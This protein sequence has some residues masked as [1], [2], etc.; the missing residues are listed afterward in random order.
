[1]ESRDREEG[2]A[3]SASIQESIRSVL[4][5]EVEQ[6]IVD[7]ETDMVMAAPANRVKIWQIVSAAFFDLMLENMTDLPMTGVCLADSV[8]TRQEKVS[9]ARNFLSA[10]HPW[11]FFH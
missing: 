6:V 11:M 1:M 4:L 3:V 7:K 5:G 8:P 9:I 10:V 2:T